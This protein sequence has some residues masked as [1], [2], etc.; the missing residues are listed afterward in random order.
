MKKEGI[1]CPFCRELI[2]AKATVCPHCHQTIPRTRRKLS[3]LF[4]KFVLLLI[5]SGIVYFVLTHWDMIRAL[6]E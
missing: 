2:D 1:R 4:W 5:L 6:W 3:R